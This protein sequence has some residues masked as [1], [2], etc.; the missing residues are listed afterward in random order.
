MNL[1][2]ISIKR[3]LPFIKLS[4]YSIQT[5][6]PFVS[7]DLTT[8]LLI[9]VSSASSVTKLLTSNEIIDFNNDVIDVDVA[10]NW[11]YN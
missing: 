6:E 2:L 4:R 3:Y 1:V 9:L 5:L 11:P 7:H 8:E 10:H